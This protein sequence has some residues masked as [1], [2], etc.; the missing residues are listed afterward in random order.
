M[1]TRFTHT[2]PAACAAL[3]VSAKTLARLRA[4]GVLKVGI[5]CRPGGVGT[6]RPRWR[7]DLVA[8]DETLSKAARRPRKAKAASAEEVM[9]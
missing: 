7:W 5:H 2:T 9:S 6:T 1:T 4:A 8:V 3:G